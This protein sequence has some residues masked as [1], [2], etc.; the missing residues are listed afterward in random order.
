MVAVT[1][2]ELP[3]RRGVARGRRE[4]QRDD[5]EGTNV[6]KFDARVD[7]RATKVGASRG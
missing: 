4:N 6:E 7:H 3:S 1:T 2:R 5:D